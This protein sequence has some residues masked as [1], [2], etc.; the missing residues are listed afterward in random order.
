M[1]RR[2]GIAFLTLCICGFADAQSLTEWR[3]TLPPAWRVDRRVL[4]VETGHTSSDITALRRVVSPLGEGDAIKLV[5]TLPGVS[6]GAEGGSAIFVRGGN[7]GSNRMTLDGVTIHGISHLLGLSS[8][9]PSDV[10]GEMD[11]RVGGFDA[12]RSP[13]TAS[14][15]Q[16]VSAE[17]GKEH[18]RAKVFLSNFLVGASLDGPV[19]KNTGILLAAR[20]SP[21]SLEY[22]AA[23]KY[24]P[25][26]LSL[27]E[28]GA[29][30]YDFYGKL[31]HRFSDTQTL[32]LSGFH[33][34]DRYRLT[35]RDEGLR[36]L[37]WHNTMGLIRY[38]D[39]SNP[40]WTL[41][42][43]LSFVDFAN[44]QQWAARFHEAEDTL[45]VRSSLRELAFDV[46]V[47]HPVQE[48]A[49]LQFG[50]RGQW[51]IFNPGEIVTGDFGNGQQNS[52]VLGTF[53]GQIDQDVSGHY[54]LKA[55]ARGNVFVLAGKTWIV[56][57]LDLLAEYHLS[58]NWMVNVTADRLVQFQHTLEGI[59]MGWSMDMIVPT[60]ATIPPETAWQ[61]YVGI[62]GG[63][64]A[65][66]LSLG[67]YAKWMDGLVH[68][69]QASAVFN[70]A[71]AGWKD[72][73]D[74]G[75]GFSFGGEFLYEL[76]LRRFYGKIAYTLSKTDRRFQNLND[77]L[78]FPAK[79]DRRHI[80]HANAEYTVSR[81]LRTGHAL[82]GGVTLQSGHWESVKD[83][84]YSGKLPG[85][86]PVLLPYFGK[87][88]NN[89]RMPTYLRVDIGYNMTI[90][91]KH[92]DHDFKFGVYNLLNRH[93]PFMLVYD[94]EQETWMELSL[95]PILPNFSYRI[96][97]K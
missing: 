78:P 57:E 24:L 84:S 25:E 16:L 75:K 89:Y 3:D 67:G 48:N 9:V 42:A 5:Q 85:K 17:P 23:R 53:W 82:T 83:F 12:D 34:R 59:P 56:P 63:M 70:T 44:Q 33:S 46:K 55:A 58:E 81:T 15:I 90:H 50:V 6:T 32:T 36:S 87:Q 4:R 62:L 35:L 80:L 64:G 77:G 14:H 37:G 47:T 91:A 2:I 73:V 68:F 40:S 93:N 10:I 39:K 86:D 54:R 31:Q 13:L 66:R 88:P 20:F 45:H 74:I 96:S 72:Q 21:L 41:D 94:T 49:H 22:K 61:G 18:L 38:S 43:G 30:V 65:H 26:Y 28:F 19:T 95:F 60:D 76:S 27:T 71:K 29:E 7:L 97:L 52:P 92:T 51:S 79:F 8:A 11:F 69:T 1:V